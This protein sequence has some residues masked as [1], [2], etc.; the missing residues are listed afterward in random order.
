MSSK[1]VRYRTRSVECAVLLSN[2]LRQPSG[3]DS[4]CRHSVKRANGDG[5]RCR[6]STDMYMAFGSDDAFVKYE[7]RSV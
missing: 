4:K 1:T 6:S 7:A 5:G 3:S 2:V